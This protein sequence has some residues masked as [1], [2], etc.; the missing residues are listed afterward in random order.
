MANNVL[1][2][3][4]VIQNAQIRP[5][6]KSN[7]EFGQWYFGCVPYTSFSKSPFSLWFWHCNQID[8]NDR[9]LFDD[10]SLSLYQ[11][12]NSIIF[13]LSRQIHQKPNEW[14]MI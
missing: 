13:L 3:T 10:I 12:V 5:N 8:G 2:L 9:T 6:P 7:L 4:L 11:S 1:E 14:R